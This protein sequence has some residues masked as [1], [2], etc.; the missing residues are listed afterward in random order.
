MDRSRDHE[1][2]MGSYDPEHEMP[3]P[4]RRPRARYQSDAYQRQSRD[5]RWD[6]DRDRDR[7]RDEGGFFD[8][9]R[10]AFDRAVDKMTGEDERYEREFDRNRGVG[11]EYRTGRSDY[12]RSR[13]RGNAWRYSGRDDDL[14]HSMWRH[15]G[16]FD[17]E[18]GPYGG[19]WDREE[20]YGNQY[21]NDRD[22][23]SRDRDD[24][25]S[26]TRDEWRDRYHGRGVYGEEG[27]YPGEFGPR[28]SFRDR[29]RGWGTRDWASRERFPDRMNAYADTSRSYRSSRQTENDFRGERGTAD[30]GGMRTNRGDRD[31]MFEGYDTDFE[32]ARGWN[33]SGRDYE[34]DRMESGRWR[35]ERPGEFGGREDSYRARSDE[36]DDDF[37]RWDSNR[38]GR[39]R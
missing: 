37:D 13:D 34:R 5:S 11:P 7:D 32:R 38:Y 39:R 3:D 18:S 17:R 30:R 28:E 21:R 23:S 19:G 26:S 16:E 14:D 36:F 4:D 9:V 24:Y 20:R 31:R 12:D 6:S 10:G 29:D 2:Y 33:P 8:R 1:D 35:S 22:R 27:T 15:A 25:R